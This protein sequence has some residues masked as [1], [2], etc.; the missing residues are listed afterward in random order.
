MEE[1]SN[2]P[3][4][5]KKYQVVDKRGNYDEETT[6]A[7]EP[8]PAAA[9]PA[10]EP[11]AGQQGGEQEEEARGIRIE[12]AFVLILNMMRDQALISLGMYY[13]APESVAPDVESAR[14]AAE[15]FRALASEHK[16]VI[17]SVLPPDQSDMPPL[18]SDIT[19][20][21]VMALNVL[22]SQI[23]VHLGLMADPMTGLVVKDVAQAKKGIDLMTSL[24]ERFKPMLPPEAGKDIDTALTNL[25]LNFINQQQ[26]P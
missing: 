15:L 23:V 5:K 24:A 20:T 13:N 3:E 1:N 16:D 11:A 6:V 25:R 12:D 4:E 2:T 18:S 17:K 22:Q 10:S 7:P 9:A 26:Q 14:R 8:A 19:A 21:L